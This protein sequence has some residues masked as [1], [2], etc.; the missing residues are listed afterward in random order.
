VEGKR[1]WAILLAVYATFALDVFSTFTSSPQTTEINAE[2]RAETLMKWVKIGVVV[3]IGG[4]AVGS[5]AAKN[6]LPLVATTTV[7][8]AMWFMYE[9]AKQAGLDSGAPGTENYSSW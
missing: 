4:G 8:V 9:H 3:A 7:A 6:P 1:T 2:A 5:Y